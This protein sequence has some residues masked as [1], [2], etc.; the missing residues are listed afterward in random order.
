[1]VTNFDFFYSIVL[2]NLEE[3]LDRVPHKPIWAT[4]SAEELVR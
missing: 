2:L 3:A 4:A 1:M